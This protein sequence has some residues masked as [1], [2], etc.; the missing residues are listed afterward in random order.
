MDASASVIRK[1]MRHRTIV[2][3]LRVL[4]NDPYSEAQV[5]L[6]LAREGWCV[7]EVHPNGIG[8]RICLCDRAKAR[9]ADR[10][11]LTAHW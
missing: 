5:L 6:S 8:V 7:C 11:I 9:R 10:S 4:G 2:G 1:R 3:R